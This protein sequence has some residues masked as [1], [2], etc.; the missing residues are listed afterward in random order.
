M[1]KKLFSSF[2]TYLNFEHLVSFAPCLFILFLL[3]AILQT[4]VCY[5]NEHLVNRSLIIIVISSQFVFIYCR[6]CLLFS[7]MNCVGNVSVTLTC[8]VILI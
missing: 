7:F 1:C 3:L 8:V 4:L 6:V 5:S 2:F